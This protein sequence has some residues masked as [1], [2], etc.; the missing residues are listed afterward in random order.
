MIFTI[1]GLPLVVVGLW[2]C[3][4][5]FLQTSAPSTGGISYPTDYSLYE[6]SHFNS[7]S[8]EVPFFYEAQEELPEAV[9][10]HS[11]VHCP[12]LVEASH[13]EWAY[14]APVLLILACNMVFLI[15]IMAV[16]D[17]VFSSCEVDY[18][19]LFPR[20]KRTEKALFCCDRDRKPMLQLSDAARR[21]KC[22]SE[23]SN[24][25]RAH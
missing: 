12:F 7:T 22:S 11:A 23:R 24:I 21:G 17:L 10:N 5:Y 9:V 13:S 15:V 19:A 25:F 16:S 4:T 14:K 18:F 6:E 3:L 2:S 20:M 8:G 1:S